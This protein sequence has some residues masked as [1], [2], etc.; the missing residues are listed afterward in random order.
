MAEVRR[1]QD[2]LARFSAGHSLRVRGGAILT[3]IQFVTAGKAV[4]YLPCT[5]ATLSDAEEYLG[6]QINRTAVTR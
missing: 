6:K 4:N 5:V 1:A 2:Y 3:S